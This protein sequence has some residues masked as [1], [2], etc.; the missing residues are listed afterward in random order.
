MA[1]TITL[2]LLVTAVAHLRDAHLVAAGELRMRLRNAWAMS[3]SEV[4][5]I[6]ADI[7]HHIAEAARLSDEIDAHESPEC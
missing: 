7:E 6:S 5:A 3:M 2:E 1:E 4:A